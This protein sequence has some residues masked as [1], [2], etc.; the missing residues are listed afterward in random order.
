MRTACNF[1]FKNWDGDPQSKLGVEASSL[2]TLGCTERCCLKEWDRR[3][4]RRFTSTSACA[5]TD[6]NTYYSPHISKHPHSHTSTQHMHPH[7]EEKENVSSFIFLN[8]SDPANTG[9]SSRFS[10]LIKNTATHHFTAPLRNFIIASLPLN[11]HHLCNIFYQLISS[12][13]TYFQL[14]LP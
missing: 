13:V 4:V 9:K 8:V 2:W 7:E 14:L 1:S 12:V 10:F 5:Y 6:S 3:A 11:P